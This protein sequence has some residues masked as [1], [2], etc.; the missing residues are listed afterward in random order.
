VTKLIKETEMKPL[1]IIVLAF[2][3]LI[4]VDSFSISISEIE[5]KLLEAQSQEDIENVIKEVVISSEYQEACKSLSD[6]LSSMPLETQ[7]D[8]EK[9]LPTI[10]SYQNLQCAYTR[11]IWGDAPEQYFE[12]RCEGLIVEF[13]KYNDQ[14]Y[15]LDKEFRRIT[16]VD[17]LDAGET[18]LSTSEFWYSRDMAREIKEDYRHKCLPNTEQCDELS[19]AKSEV[20]SKW[21]DFEQNSLE[22]QFVSIDMQRIQDRITLTC[23]YQSSLMSYY[24]TQEKYFGKPIP[25]E[26]KSE[27]V[28][29]PNL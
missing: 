3:L 27:L 24:E 15:D 25:V 29:D 2:I 5:E 18:W 4:P 9:A 14:H 17:G 16:S 26:A 28:P 19:I 6:K 22:Q 7:A 23:G 8:G 12:T 1:I 20:G 10:Q 21:S 11:N 13:E